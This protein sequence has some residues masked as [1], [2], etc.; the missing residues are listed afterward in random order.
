MNPE[1]PVLSVSGTYQGMGVQYGSA[2]PDLIKRNVDNY[3]HRFQDERGLS[4][5]QVRRIGA[6]VRT[7]IRAYSADLAD[8]LDGVAE[9]AG[10]EPEL[11][12]ALNA[13]TE[14]LYDT[15]TEDGGCTSLAVLPSHSAKGDT[16]LGQNWDWQPDQADLSLMLHTQDHHGLSILALTEAGMLVKSGVN[17]HGLGVCVNLLKSDRDGGTDGV[18][19]HILARGILQSATIADAISSVVRQKRNCSGNLLVADAGGEAISLE[20]VPD[21]FGHLLPTSGLLA[22]A[23]H[24]DSTVAVKDRHRGESP[25][26]L[27]RPSRVRHALEPRLAARDVGLDDIQRIFRD[28]FSYPHGICRHEAPLGG[29]PSKSS[30]LYSVI[31][32][33]GQRSLWVAAGPPCEHQ[34]RLVQT[35]RH[36]DQPVAQGATT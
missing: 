22:H 12:A 5:E 24:F 25:L 29:Q 17:S 6:Q 32:D 14:I 1:I 31:M 10:V 20:L 3:L 11:L 7:S 27:L 13:R 36:V 26:T 9:G 28:H 18:P 2:M 16:W 15:T 4:A 8:M 34:Y 19:F 35:E 21:D 30:T 23:N 33:L